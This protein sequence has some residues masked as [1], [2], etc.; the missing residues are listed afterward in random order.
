MPSSAAPVGSGLF[1]GF[2]PSEKL[3][4]EQMASLLREFMRDHA[5]L[6]RLIQGVEHSTRLITWALVDCIDDW[7]TTPPLIGPV[8]ILNFPSK[9]LLLR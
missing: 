2:L 5:E 1:G 8:G 6:N 3:A 9:R 7:N 4:F